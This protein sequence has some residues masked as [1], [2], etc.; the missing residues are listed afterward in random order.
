MT[1]RFESHELFTVMRGEEV[2][3]VVECWRDYGVVCTAIC[4]SNG[5]ARHVARCIAPRVAAGV[6]SVPPEWCLPEKE[7]ADAMVASYRSLYPR[8]GD[9]I[10][11]GVS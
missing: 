11:R 2:V 6:Y 7:M 1:A 5:S 3:G 4:T 9:C 10:E 8:Q